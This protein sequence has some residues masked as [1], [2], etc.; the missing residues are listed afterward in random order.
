MLFMPLIYHHTLF[1]QIA[2]VHSEHLQLIAFSVMRD[3][4]KTVSKCKCYHALIYGIY[5]LINKKSVQSTLWGL[6]LG[7]TDTASLC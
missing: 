3:N 5:F 2:I 6:Y 7:I 4:I 1:V